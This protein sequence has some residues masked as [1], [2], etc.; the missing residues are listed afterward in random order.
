M[1][2]VLTDKANWLARHGY[3]VTIITTEQNGRPD[4]FVLDDTIS[5]RDLAIGYEDNNG[6]SLWDKVIHYPK[7]QYLHRKRLTQVLSEIRPD[8]TVSMFCNDVNL[9]PQI[10]CTGKKVLEVHF[11]RYKRLQYGR[12]GLWGL[13]DR[14]RSNNEIQLV[15]KYDRFVTLTGEDRSLW[16]DVPGICT[17]PNGIRLPELMPDTE[18]DSTV[19]AVGRYMQQKGLDRMIDAWKIVMDTLGSDSKWKLHFWGDGELRKSLQN[20]IDSL[21]LNDSA[22]LCGTTQDMTSVYRRA[23]ILAMSSHYEGLPM[24][25]IEAQAYGIPA[26]SF[27][28]QCGP[29]EVIIDGETGLLV[30][31]GDVDALARALLR[32]IQDTEERKRMSDEA[33][34]NASRFELEAIMLQWDS[35][36][37]G[38]Q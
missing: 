36:F 13:V 27:D 3:E 8:I 38:L 16:G 19:I 10:K 6:G 20:Q 26:V 24:A 25:L 29:K 32:L 17:I 11:S 15:K 30:R 31:N 12:K 37:K 7:K 34:R 9:I 23:S 4:A 2:K 21:G 14:I 22:V 35:L 33:I 18:R 5:R 1:E 28:C